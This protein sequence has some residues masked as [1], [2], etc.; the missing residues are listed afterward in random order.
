ME[1]TKAARISED[2]KYRYTLSRRWA[3][4]EVA[5]FVMLNPSTADAQIDDRTI[6]RCIAF[7]RSWGMGGI[8]VVNLYAYRATKP[9]ALWLAEDPVGPENDWHLMEQAHFAFLLIA[10]WG[11]NA[12]PGR[13]AEVLALPGMDQLMALGVTKDGHP[14]HPL[15]LRGDARLTAWGP[16]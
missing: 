1:M 12:K 14:R 16:S 4:G 3:A 15:Y 13:V 8:T 9:A 7:A 11:V 6:G 10:A 5:S 2:G